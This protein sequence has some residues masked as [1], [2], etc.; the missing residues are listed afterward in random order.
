MKYQQQILNYFFPQQA[1]C[2]VFV[3]VQIMTFIPVMRIGGQHNK[4]LL[5]S[6]TNGQLRL[7]SS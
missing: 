4:E 5:A 2:W 7:S 6:I 1:F 3:D